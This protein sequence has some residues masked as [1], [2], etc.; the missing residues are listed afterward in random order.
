MPKA[1]R[2]EWSF[3]VFVFVK[4]FATSSLVVGL[5]VWMILGNI[6]HSLIKNSL[7]SVA[8]AL[9]VL[10]PISPRYHV[11]P[12]SASRLHYESVGLTPKCSNTLRAALLTMFFFR[13]DAV[14]WEIHSLL[15]GR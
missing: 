5:C 2:F 4:L 7:F 9:F 6:D 3:P 13:G 8:A 12:P 10:F 1:T 11:M 14:I 15:G